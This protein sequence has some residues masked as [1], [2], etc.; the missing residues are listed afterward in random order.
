METLTILNTSLFLLRS[1]L[2]LVLGDGEITSYLVH[3]ISILGTHNLNDAKRSFIF[4]TCLWFQVAI[5]TERVRTGMPTLEGSET[6]AGIPI[7]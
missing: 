3:H 2:A 1:I 7:K 6:Q 5:C 4:L